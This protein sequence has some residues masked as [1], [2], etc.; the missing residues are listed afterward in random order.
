MPK[1]KLLTKK[2]ERQL[3]PLY[4]QD[5]KGDDAICYLKLSD[6]C[7]QWTW[8]AT[9]YDPEQRLFFGLVHGHYVELG[10]FSLDELEQ[11]RNAWGLPLERDMYFEPTTIGEIRQQLA[12][13][14]GGL[15]LKSDRL[16]G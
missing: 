11:V 4:A 3:P 9:E 14:W 12:D 7:S 13:R 8:F 15:L 16:Y 5:G 6:P 10:Y 2:I 1:M